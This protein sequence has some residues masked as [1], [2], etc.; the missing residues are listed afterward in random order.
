MRREKL[1]E[2]LDRYA[3]N[4]LTT[5][6]AISLIE[7][8]YPTSEFQDFLAANPELKARGDALMEWAK[9]TV[10]VIMKPKII[11]FVMREGLKATADE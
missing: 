8:L 7:T 6:G 4:L 10:P 1:K 2:I 11:A 3:A 9:L 5:D